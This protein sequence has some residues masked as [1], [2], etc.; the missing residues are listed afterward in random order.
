MTASIES[1]DDLR[2]AWRQ[3]EQRLDHHLTLDLQRR[4]AG[5]LA[6]VRRVLRP[7]ALG[8]GVQLVFGLVLTLSCGV[9]GWKFSSQAPVAISAVALGLYGLMTAVFAVRDLVRLQALDYAAPVLEVQERLARLRTGRLRA[10][11]WFAAGGCLMW[12][13]GLVLLFAGMGVNVWAR[14]P[15]AVMLWIASSLLC[16]ALSAGL[17]AWSR[18]PGQ[19]RLAQWLQ[20]QA[21]GLS[22]TRAQ[23]TLDEV[24][25]YEREPR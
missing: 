10:G 13:P 17:L 18:R 11:W 2:G 23:A 9:M 6:R 7:L 19:A 4:R 21:A 1:I 20:A 16:L 14:S 24:R 22:L 12:T 3:L 8:Q 15:L 5:G 25:A